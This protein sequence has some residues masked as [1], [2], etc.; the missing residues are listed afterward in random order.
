MTASV[1][2]DTNAAVAICRPDLLYSCALGLAIVSGIFAAFRG[3]FLILTLLGVLKEK[4]V[5]A[6]L[7]TTGLLFLPVMVLASIGIHASRFGTL[8]WDASD[9]LFYNRL[10]E[11][12]RWV[13][14][15]D[16]R[17]VYDVSLDFSTSLSRAAL[18]E[19]GTS[20]S[21]LCF[22]AVPASLT[23]FTTAPAKSSHWN[24]GAFT[25]WYAR[26]R[27]VV[28]L[29]EPFS[30]NQWDPLNPTPEYN[31][32]HQQ[33]TVGACFGA[34]V[35]AESIVQA[36]AKSDACLLKFVDEEFI[37]ENGDVSG[38]VCAPGW[39][40]DLLRRTLFCEPFQNCVSRVQAAQEG[41]G[42]G[43][44]AQ[45]DSSWS[46]QTGWDREE[47]VNDARLGQ[48]REQMSVE[49]YTLVLTYR[50]VDSE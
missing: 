16:R 44:P 49:L 24:F 36:T 20:A 45:V 21:S 28:P 11:I 38:S 4:V 14:S 3:T 19:A 12:A 43:Q 22:A 6:C 40:L 9:S 15:H 23:A 34:L 30:L 5:F 42:E 10:L 29:E 2:R 37:D 17:K 26:R 32:L 18:E 46:L 48:L 50:L 35:D 33:R 8:D 41:Y 13:S 7:G 39:D 1:V 25:D 27:L 47:A 31:A